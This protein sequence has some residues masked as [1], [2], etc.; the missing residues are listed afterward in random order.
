MFYYSESIIQSCDLWIFE[1][2]FDQ[3]YPTFLWLKKKT[4]M[5][6]DSDLWIFVK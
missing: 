6:Q 4:V 1:K 3:V 5:F 2:S